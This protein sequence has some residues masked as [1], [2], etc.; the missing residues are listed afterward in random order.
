MTRNAGFLRLRRLGRLGGHAHAEI[1]YVARADRCGPS[2][3]A[4]QDGRRSLAAL[5]RR[6]D[7]TGDGGRD[8]SRAVAYREFLE[9]A[10][11][12]TF[13]G[14]FADEQVP[15]DLWVG[16]PSVVGVKVPSIGGGA[17]SFP[18]PCWPA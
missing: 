5:R 3:T 16:H 6:E 1:G 17:Q 4:K 11:D 8:C 12:V 10:D 9:D 13:H 18:L 7:A 2:A 14:R 15:S